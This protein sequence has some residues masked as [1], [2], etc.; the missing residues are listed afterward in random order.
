MTADSAQM[1]K[2]R[3]IHELSLVP[4]GLAQSHSS[5][6]FFS[7]KVFNRLSAIDPHCSSKKVTRFVLLYYKNVEGKSLSVSLRWNPLI[8]EF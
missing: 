7:L 2:F 8:C 5:I 3:H 1:T 4:V 6:Y